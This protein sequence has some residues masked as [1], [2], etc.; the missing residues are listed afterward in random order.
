[1][2]LGS[3]DETQKTSYTSDN[4]YFACLIENHGHHVDGLKGCPN[5]INLLGIQLELFG[6]IQVVHTFCLKTSQLNQLIERET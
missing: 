6:G 4:K 5:V 2:C 1:M 3:F